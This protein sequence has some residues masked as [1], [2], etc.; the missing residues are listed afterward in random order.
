MYTKIFAFPLKVKK[1]MNFQI[2]ANHF[3]VCVSPRFF[4]KLTQSRVKTQFMRLCS[5]QV[6]RLSKTVRRLTS[7]LINKISMN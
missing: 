1:Q 4:R 3:V 6:L 5:K 2:S 7:S